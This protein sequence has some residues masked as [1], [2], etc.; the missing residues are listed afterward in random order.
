MIAFTIG[1]T[2]G[3]EDTVDDFGSVEE[4]VK[5]IN[6]RY[7]DFFRYHRELEERWEKRRASADERKKLEQAHAQRLENA[8]Q[9]YV[10]TRRARPSDEPLRLRW[11]AEQK[12]AARPFGNV[13]QAV[14]A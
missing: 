8:R 5:R 3:A 14:C 12:R 6:Q 4:M 13:A 1:L 11:E 2:C 7:D 9:E 10:K